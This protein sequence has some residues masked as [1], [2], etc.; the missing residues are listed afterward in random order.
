MLLRMICC[1]TFCLF[2][3]A[4]PH[5]EA[6]EE[7]TFPST[8]PVVDMNEYNDITTK[9]TF[10]DK[11][12]QAL[13]E[14]GFFAVINSNIDMAALE[15]AYQASQDFFNSPIERK[16]E[17]Y[18]PKLNGQRGYVPGETA[19]GYKAKDFKEFVHIGRKDNLWPLWMELQEPMEELIATLDHD[20]EIL[21]KV[22]ALAIGEE[23]DFFI[24]MTKSGECL[25]RALHYPK[26]PSPGLFWAAKHTDIDLFSILPMATEDGLQIFHEGTWINVRVPPNALIINGGDKLQNLTNGYF[27]SCLH[28][29]V[30]KPNVERYS[31]VYF[32]H[33]RNQD[34]MSPTE[35]CITLTGGVQRYPQ[36]TRLELL[37]CRL[38]ELGLASPALLEYEKESGIMERITKL[39]EE[40]IA[41]EPVQLTYALWLKGQSN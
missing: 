4:S 11:V 8:I 28:Q 29:V 14:V 34:S 1:L 18:D 17:I 24:K 7:S 39:V 23:E 40:G 5:I 35:H 37:A 3:S 41:A 38:R 6:K 10:V 27:K 2:M 36:A 30:S 22:F 9:Q 15:R 31:I 16:N 19:Q 20:S 13:H 33:P 12:A 25:L 21:Q 26:N 32:I